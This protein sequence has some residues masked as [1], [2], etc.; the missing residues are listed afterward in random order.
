MTTNEE[1]EVLLQRCQDLANSIVDYV[2]NDLKDLKDKEQLGPVMVGALHTAYHS[3][4]L[5]VYGKDQF[6]KVLKDTLKITE[7]AQPRLGEL[8]AELKKATEQK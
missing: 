4:G 7:E 2:Q 6:L 3:V 5:A 1:R 8:H